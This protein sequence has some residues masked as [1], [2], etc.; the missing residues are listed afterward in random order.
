M[1]WLFY[2]VIFLCLYS[3]PPTDYTYVN[4]NSPE[5]KAFEEWIHQHGIFLL[6][7]IEHKLKLMEWRFKIIQEWIEVGR[8][9]LSLILGLMAT[10]NIAVNDTLIEIGLDTVMFILLFSSYLDHH[11]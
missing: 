5:I 9:F 3:I 10:D 11:H 4:A 7:M 6:Y 8:K 1:H 2:L